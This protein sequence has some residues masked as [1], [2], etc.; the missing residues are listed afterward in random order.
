MEDRAAVAAVGT[1]SYYSGCAGPL[2][3]SYG[4]RVRMNCDAFRNSS[5]NREPWHI[6][7]SIGHLGLLEN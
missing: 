7:C 6:Q 5:F 1:F 3:C 4:S 2:V